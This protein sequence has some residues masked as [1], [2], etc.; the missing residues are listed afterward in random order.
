MNKIGTKTVLKK[1]IG[2][3]RILKEVC[4]GRIVYQNTQRGVNNNVNNGQ[5]SQ[6]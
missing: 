3:K 1:Y 2:N 4:N 6:Q 5:N